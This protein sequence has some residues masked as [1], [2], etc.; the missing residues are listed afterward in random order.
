MKKLTIVGVFYSGYKDLWEDFI[1]LLKRNWG[2]CPY[3]IVIVSDT[4]DEVEYKGVRLVSVGKKAEYSR[5]V[6]QV[7]N[8][9]DSEYYLLLLEDFFF[10]APIDNNRIY[11]I[12]DFVEQN[13]IKYYA[14][15]MEEF[16]NNYKGYKID[17]KIRSISPKAEYTVSCQPAIWERNFLKQCVGTENYNA[18]IFEGIYAKA[19]FAHTEDF[20]KGCVVDISNPL[21]IKH[22]VLQG[23]MVPTTVDYFNKQDYEFCSQRTIFSRKLYRKQQFKIFCRGLMP[24]WLQKSVKNIFKTKSIIGNFEV[25]IKEIMQSMHLE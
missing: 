21:N 11:H 9:I 18:W 22:G 3:D 17:S 12:L 5:K 8:Q 19:K 10:G 24:Y 2:N 15:P 7:L 1:T 6:Q 25:Q 16:S 13:Q 20:L 14:M 4:I 23:K